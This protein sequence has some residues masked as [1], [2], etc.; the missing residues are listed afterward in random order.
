[1]MLYL[2]HLIHLFHIDTLFES[3]TARRLIIVLFP[4]PQ[5]DLLV[6]TYSGY[7]LILAQFHKK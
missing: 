1:M 2:N 4:L 5:L 3:R 6:V 7:R